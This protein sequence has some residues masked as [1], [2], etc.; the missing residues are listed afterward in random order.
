MSLVAIAVVVACAI[1]ALLFGQA[2]FFAGTPV[3]QLHWLLTQG[4]CDGAGRALGPRG[5][6]RLLR[7]EECCCETSNPAVQVF[8]CVLL[9]ACYW[10]YV[11]EVFTMLPLPGVA[12]WHL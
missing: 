11:A 10:V 12:H 2:R 8:F 4:I 6:A 3:A 7:L 1:F 5:R 9:G